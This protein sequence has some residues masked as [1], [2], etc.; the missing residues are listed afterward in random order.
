M[1]KASTWLYTAA[2]HESKKEVNK[3]I[4]P[5]WAKNLRAEADAWALLWAAK[6]AEVTLGDRFKRL[7]HRLDSV[8]ERLSL[9][10][11]KSDDDPILVQKLRKQVMQL[12]R[13]L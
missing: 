12:E 9:T 3:E 11:A 4:R 13:K 2:I 10:Q 6:P 5:R 1:W 8:D 7:D